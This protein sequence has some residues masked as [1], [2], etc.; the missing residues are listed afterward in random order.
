MFRQ[1]FLKRVFI[2]DSGGLDIPNAA[3]N[4]EHCGTPAKVGDAEKCAGKV[5]VAS[6]SALTTEAIHHAKYGGRGIG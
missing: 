4:C 3:K 6:L 5:Q 2:R 1:P